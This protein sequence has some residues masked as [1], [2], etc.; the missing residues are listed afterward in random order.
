MSSDRD[1]EFM[2]EAIAAA[3]QGASEGGIPIGE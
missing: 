2:R 3:K 1:E